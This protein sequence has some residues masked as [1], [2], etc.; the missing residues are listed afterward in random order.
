[1]PMQPDARAVGPRGLCPVPTSGYPASSDCFLDCSACLAAARFIALGPLFFFFRRA[2]ARSDLE[3]LG[4]GGMPPS[5]PLTRQSFD[6]ARYRTASASCLRAVRAAVIIP[7]PLV[8]SPERGHA[9]S[10][11]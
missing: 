7:S 4:V 6:L 10:G 1:V 5:I 8:A 2:A 9:P 3:S 11:R